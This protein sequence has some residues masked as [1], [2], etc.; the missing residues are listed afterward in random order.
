MSVAQDRDNKVVA[1]AFAKWHRKS[2]AQALDRATV[3]NI[4]A[5]KQERAYFLLVSRYRPA[6]DQMHR[7][8]SES[9]AVLALALYRKGCCS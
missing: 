7:A 5:S 2:Q 6:A 3:E 1:L 4:E 8:S 9:A